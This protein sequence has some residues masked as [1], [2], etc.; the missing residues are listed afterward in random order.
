MNEE[1]LWLRNFSWAE[2]SS[3][4]TV[5]PRAHKHCHVEAAVHQKR[6]VNTVDGNTA[7]HVVLVISDAL[8][9]AAEALF[10]HAIG[11]ECEITAAK[12]DTNDSRRINDSQRINSC[13]ISRSAQVVLSR[14][15]TPTSA[16]PT[17][18]AA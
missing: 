18:A 9:A 14:L 6:I 11:D 12:H 8:C 2:D 16:S 10:D 4:E 1:L 7:S 3:R 15:R 13:R 5:V 17:P